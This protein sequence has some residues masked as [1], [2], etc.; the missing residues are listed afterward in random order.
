MINLCAS[1]LK[2]CDELKKQVI[3]DYEG[4]DMDEELKEEFDEDF[5]EVA[6]IMVGNTRFLLL[7][8]LLFIFFFTLENYHCL[9]FFFC[10]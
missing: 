8:I 4:E 2:V 6:E 3:K 7:C 5:E 9:S 10:I 1:A